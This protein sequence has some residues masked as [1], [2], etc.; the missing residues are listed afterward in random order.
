MLPRYV[1]GL[2][3]SISLAARDDREEHVGSMIAANT[4]SR[5]ASR[6]RLPWMFIGRRRR[7]EPVEAGDVG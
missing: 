7:R 4:A 5:G 3:C 6:V 1:V 2:V